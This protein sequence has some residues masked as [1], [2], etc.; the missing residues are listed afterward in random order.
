MDRVEVQRDRRDDHGGVEHDQVESGRRERTIGLDPIT[1]D[2]SE[3]D[4]EQQIDQRYDRNGSQPS[5]ADVTLAAVRLLRL[6]ALFALMAIAACSFS[7]R[8]AGD[9]GGGGNES[10]A[11]DGPPRYR[12]HIRVTAPSTL[13]LTGFVIA[14]ATTDPAIAQHAQPDG[15]DLGFTDAQ[16]TRL[17]FELVHYSAGAVEAWVRLPALAGTADLYLTYGAG[18][19][20]AMS[21]WDAATYAGVWH[22]D[23]T[24]GAWHDS[25]GGHTVIAPS[26]AQTPTSTLGILGNALS[27]D[28]VD[29]ATTAGD[30][31]DGSLDFGT[32][33]FTVEAW[34]NVTTS[35]NSHDCV[36][37][38]G[39]IGSNPGYLLTLGTGTWYYD[40]GDNTQ[41]VETAFG[42]ET[43]LLGQW[44]HLVGVTDRNMKQDFAYLDGAQVA[45]AGITTTGSIDSPQDFSIG[46]TNSAVRFEGVADEVRVYKVALSADWIA[47][48]HANLADPAHFLTIDSE[49]AY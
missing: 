34:V 20:T 27:F 5:G 9:A 17:P 6:C 7:A 43:S 33:S 19:V 2:Q 18:A 4:A 30:P 24:S 3:A 47:A 49:Q 10:H 40:I 46:S 21:P 36:V 38:K 1:R 13:P 29:D 35:S 32:S 41:T 14:I 8:L 11:I 23:E 16:G 44:H 15:S 39:S 25:A 28:G 42:P 22:F 37:D 48:E 45:A 26:P 12:K 31:A